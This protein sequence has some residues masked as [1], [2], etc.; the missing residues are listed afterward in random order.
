MKYGVNIYLVTSLLIFG[1]STAPAAEDETTSTAPASEDERSFVI[2][3]TNA[4]ANKSVADT[5]ELLSLECD[6]SLSD[7]NVRSKMKVSD[8][9]EKASAA[10]QCLN[11][12]RGIAIAAASDT[13][14]KAKMKELLQPYID[15]AI[16]VK[17]QADAENSFLGL[18]WGLGFGY[19][20][21]GDEMIDDAVIVNGIVR[22]KSQ[23]KQQ[24]RLV[25]EFHRYLWCND[26]NKDGTRG[27]GPF[28][29][30]AATQDKALSGVG[31]G[32]MYGMKA[33]ASDTE[34]FSIGAGAILDSKVKDLADGFKKDEAAPAGETLRFEEKSR[35]SYL[36]FVTRTF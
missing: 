7:P 6:L 29:A 23:K 9:A 24:P 34:G 32:F 26:D 2:E 33:K 31:M 3:L 1:A 12:G 19:S 10:L 30:V 5:V 20:F 28:V 16:Q 22:G 17:Q 14:K 18:T 21:A 8:R 11:K 36:I 25:L 13:E 27:C 4:V 35:W 15:E